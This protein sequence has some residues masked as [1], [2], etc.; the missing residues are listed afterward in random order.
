M[1]IGLHTGAAVVGNM[2]SRLR[3]DYT[4]LGDAVNLASRLEGANKEFGTRTMVSWSAF[5]AAGAICAGRELGLLR[6]V[7]R[8]E[9]VRVLE[10]LR[11]E[12]AAAKSELL[13][14]FA[15]GLEAF[16]AGRVGEAME[17]FA[18]IAPTD[19]PA[20]A[21]LKRCA[22]LPDPLPPDWSGIWELAGK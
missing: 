4:V 7:G 3:F 6:V 13:R 10:P 1:R 21:Y 5:T 15:S 16:Q 14:I 17:R 19:P 22:V 12:E 18:C 11:H 9:A 2:G 20:A 8:R